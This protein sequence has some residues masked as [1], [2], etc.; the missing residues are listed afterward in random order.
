MHCPRCSSTATTTQK[1]RSAL[2][3]M[4]LNHRACGR[5]W[6]MQN[7]ICPSD[8]RGKRRDL[9]FVP[10][11]LPG[12]VGTAQ[13]QC[14]ERPCTR[15]L[16]VEATPNLLALI[17]TTIDGYPVEVSES[18]EIRARWGMRG[19]I[20]SACQGLILHPGRGPR[21]PEHRTSDLPLMSPGTV[22]RDQSAHSGP[23]TAKSSSMVSRLARHQ[24]AMEY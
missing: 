4:R 22:R 14:G 5:P 11:T 2:G 1:H 3:Y 18:G 12:V 8:P 6:G 20:R 19:K 13:G 15:I 23:V 21:F 16:V 9:V 24:M 7:P 17:P 10:H